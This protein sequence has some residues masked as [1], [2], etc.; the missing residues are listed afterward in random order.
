[1][2][3]MGGKAHQAGYVALAIN[4][5]K[6][7]RDHYVEPF[8]GGGSVFSRVA[9]SF[10][11]AVGGDQCPSLIA[12]WHETI[13]EGFRPPRELSRE[14]WARLRD[15]PNP[16]ALKAWAG[17]ACSYSG[18]WFAGYGA[19]AISAGRNYL[20]EAYWSFGYKVKSLKKH[21]NVTFVCADYESH[22]IDENTVVYC[23]PPY[24]NTQSYDSSKVAFDHDRFWKVAENWTNKGALV[25]VHEYKA[26]DGWKAVVS[27]DR[28]VTL[29]YSSSVV[30]SERLW[31]L[32]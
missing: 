1:M 23:D 11:V 13:H 29:D 8:I 31:M 20:E 22:N 27:R 7:N 18:K 3:Y 21:S 10:S 16:S 12:L 25:L 2:R 28:N 26:P 17:Y 6:G 24:R 4:R 9:P 19:V 32:S 30:E 5:L 15:D 14:D